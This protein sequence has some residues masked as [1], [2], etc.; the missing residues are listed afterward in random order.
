YFA[1]RT[2]YY[3]NLYVIGRDLLVDRR[4]V[5]S[6]I[7][8]VK[9][10]SSKMQRVNNVRSYN[11]KYHSIYSEEKQQQLDSGVLLNTVC[12]WLTIKLGYRAGR[13]IVT[14]DFFEN[15]VK[16]NLQR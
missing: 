2:P 12:H 6:V 7:P 9:V 3:K 1:E 8:V 13:S 4:R 14:D 10:N 15:D 11:T 5:N 16:A